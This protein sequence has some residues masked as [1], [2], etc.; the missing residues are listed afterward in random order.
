M[1]LYHIDPYDTLLSGTIYINNSAAVLVINESTN[2]ALGSIE[3]NVVQ[4]A[5]KE[6]NQLEGYDHIPTTDLE[7]E[8]TDA[9]VGGK[10]LPTSEILQPTMI[11]YGRKI[12]CN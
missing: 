3:Q 4:L 11:Y 10:T 8:N 7:E 2:Q 1:S 6:Y 9:K 12:L 5:V